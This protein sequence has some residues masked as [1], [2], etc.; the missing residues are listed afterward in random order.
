M[1]DD[2]DKHYNCI[3]GT[4]L[5]SMMGTDQFLKYLNRVRKD[6]CMNII[7][8]LMLHIIRGRTKIYILGG[9]HDTITSKFC[10]S[11]CNAI[12]VLS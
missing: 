9:S 7:T 3:C 10:L 6:I 5:L 1:F 8:L 12:R 2:R 11:R 4:I